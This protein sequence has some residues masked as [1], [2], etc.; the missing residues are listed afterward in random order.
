MRIEH[1]QITNYKCL[2]QLTLDSLGNRIVLV[3]PNG[4]GKSA[5]LD[6]IAVLKE[7]TGTYRPSGYERTFS[8]T[9]VFASGWP[10]QIRVP[11]R[12]GQ[13]QARIEARVSFTPEE[14]AQFINL[15]DQADIAVMIES[16]GVVSVNGVSDSIRQLFRHYAPE[17][18]IGVVDYIG[19][20]R[21]FPTT[22]VS[23][24]DLDVLGPDRQR[25]ERV[26]FP[27]STDSES[28]FAAVK[29]FIIAQ[30]LNDFTASQDAPNPVDSLS[31]LKELFRR[32]FAPKALAGVRTVGS[33]FQ[34]MV[35][36][37][38]GVHDIDLLSS[39]EK[40]LLAILVNLYRIRH[41]PSLVLYDEPERH[42]NAG[43]EAKIVPALDLLQSRNQL[44]IATHGVEL[45]GS[46]PLSDIVALRR[47]GEQIVAQRHSAANVTA[48]V[49]LLE[50][51]G[52]RVGL[53]FSAS[54][55]VFLEGKESHADKRILDRLLGAALPGVVFV[56][57]GASTGV[58]GTGTRAGVL[59]EAASVDAAVRMVIDRDYRS[60][61]EIRSLGQRLGD[62]IFIWPAHEIENLLLSPQHIL[63]VLNRSG[64]TEFRDENEILEGLR[65]CAE[66]LAERFACERAAYRLTIN[67]T[68][69]A[70][71]S[72]S[73]G[74]SARPRDEAGYRAMASAALARANRVYANAVVD[75]ALSEARIATQQALCSVGWQNELPGKEILACFRTRHLPGMNGEVFKEQI[76]S[77]MVES[78]ELPAAVM[79][80]RNFVNCA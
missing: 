41:L 67:T 32:F 61:E 21:V 35:N 37:P 69:S 33:E 46:L 38:D 77:A 29:Q 9:G 39:G 70:S 55:I 43:L 12:S 45:I 17:S 78:A 74:G 1:L 54:R 68:D 4:S 23:S 13:R 52:V 24:L 72:D 65:S 22:R 76:V 53:Q 71:A 64:S 34:V 50:D 28:K 26:P 75:A 8:E 42:L 27:G 10:E 7:F 20:A 58:I 80:L 14:Q 66:S 31:L 60:E 3:G 62:R 63:N 5:V 40:E 36:T 16:D 48:R 19:A 56:A 59:L 44:F 47:E 57:S 51:L 49:R 73:A 30:Q 6:A 25:R 2:A 18:G 11:V 15:S 79:S